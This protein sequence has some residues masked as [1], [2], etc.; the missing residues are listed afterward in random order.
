[1]KYLVLGSSGQIGQCL[2]KYLKKLNHV[3]IEYDIQRSVLEDL[4][5][6]ED[7]HLK[8]DI[9][10]YYINNCDFVFFL[11][12]D[13]GG[14]K[15]LSL[16]DNTFGLIHNNIS[17]MK[18]TFSMI[19]K[20]KK[21]FIFTSSQM[22]NMNHSSYG[23]TKNIGEKYT[24]S[25]GGLWVRLWN[26]YGYEHVNPKSHVITDFIEMALNGD[27]FMKSNGAESRQ[28]LYVEDCCEALYLLSCKYNNIPREEELHITSYVW[29]TIEK[30]AQIIS[31]KCGCNYIKSSLNDVV[32]LNIKEKPNKN[33]LK[34]WKPQTDI[35]TGIEY[36]LQRRKKWDFLKQNRMSGY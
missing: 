19:K 13:V 6:S 29:T 5:F 36:I 33:I 21:P 17:I 28:F 16:Y 26:V 15:Y 22:S 20:Y 25:L 1:M 35:E 11:A 4:C 9:L 32:Q 27:I 12:W 14:S 3:V 8:K 34:Y 7:Y 18:N 23:I 24:N 2:V 31:S 30:I 10:E